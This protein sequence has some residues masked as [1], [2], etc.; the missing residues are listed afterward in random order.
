MES[1]LSQNLKAKSIISKNK[2]ENTKLKCPCIRRLILSILKIRTVA[3]T[4][5]DAV[6]N[7]TVG[8]ENKTESEASLKTDKK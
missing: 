6:T 2:K 5:S 8:A 3:S 7:K 1:T 4:T